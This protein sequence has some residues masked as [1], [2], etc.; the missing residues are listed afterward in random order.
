MCCSH[1]T[2]KGLEDVMASNAKA[3][4]AGVATEVTAYRSGSERR[5]D[6]WPRL[7]EG[8]TPDV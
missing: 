1:S 2:A 8:L 6:T 4:G 7:F 5:A 3:V